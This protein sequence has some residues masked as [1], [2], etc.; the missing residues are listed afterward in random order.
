[1]SNY[2]TVTQRISLLKDLKKEI[3]AN[4]QTIYDAIYKDFGKCQFEAFITEYNFVMAELNQ[5][6]SKTKTWSK[7]KSVWPS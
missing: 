6:I 4:E 5:A 1:M 2:L 3:K 7:P